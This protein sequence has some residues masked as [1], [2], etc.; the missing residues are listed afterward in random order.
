MQTYQEVNAF[1]DENYL[2]MVTNS[3]REPRTF[4][5]QFSL[6]GGSPEK[7]PTTRQ[8]AATERKSVS[9]CKYAGLNY[10]DGIYRIRE[11]RKLDWTER[12]QAR[13]E[14]QQLQEV[15]ESRARQVSA[16]KLNRHPQQLTSIKQKQLNNP[17]ILQQVVSKY[18]L[19]R[20]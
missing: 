10:F 1:K 4:N 20:G 19:D 8:P 15:F 5:D 9:P 17:R 2:A 3:H 11:D 18:T 6:G 7:P 16:Q 12:K 14:F 13:E